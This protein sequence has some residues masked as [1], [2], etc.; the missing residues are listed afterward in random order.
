MIKQA[1]EF[2]LEL[3]NLYITPASSD[4][5]VV[6]GNIALLDA[7]NDASADLLTNKVVASVINIQQEAT[8]RNL[9]RKKPGV[10]DSG[11]P[12]AIAQSPPIYLNL[13]LLF[14]ANNTKYEDALF[15]ISEVISFFQ[16]EPSFR[17][18]AFPAL[19]PKYPDLQRI[20]M[21]T[22]ELYSTTF[23]EL[24]QIWGVLGG[25]YVPSAL[26]K[27]RLIPIQAAP[28]SDAS[29]VRSVRLDQFTN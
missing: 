22:A 17:P 25:K 3:M 4:D 2:I 13:Y 6:P 9:P 11:D 20:E 26:Y 27:L 16:I 15:Y 14:S 10:S 1:I 18:N 7:Y 29:V 8:L 23:E 5:A 24:N 19:V 28:E 21:M 12:V